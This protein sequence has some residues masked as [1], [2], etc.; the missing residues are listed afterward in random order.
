MS[1]I[2]LRQIRTDGGTQ[3]RAG[4]DE[5]TVSEY[6]DAIQ[7]GDTFPPV[8]IY[9]DGSNHWLADGFHRVAAHKQAGKQRIAAEIRQGTLRDAV[10]QS[11]GANATH[12]L[13]R[14][15]DDKRRAVQRLLDDPEW[16]Q[17]SNREIAR[18]CNVSD[19]FVGKIRPLTANVCSEERKFTTKHGTEAVMKTPVNTMKVLEAV[20]A[21]LRKQA[22]TDDPAALAALARNY[23]GTENYMMQEMILL[24][25]H[26][27]FGWQ[28]DAKKIPYSMIK[29]EMANAAR[30]YQE[31]NNQQINN[32]LEKKEIPLDKLKAALELLTAVSRMNENQRNWSKVT[33][34]ETHDICHKES[35][36]FWKLLQ[37][38][39]K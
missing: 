10:L 12:G 3:P 14:T 29:E 22:K 19:V 38:I 13:R 39:L 30:L 20:C 24:A 8:T 5:T 35:R 4:L 1:N 17:W 9:F 16:S 33:C 11:V 31:Q 34:E 27:Q 7:R 23:V 36:P 15:N 28:S 37:E 6:A 2:D 18:K 32:L 25:V 26:E 21:F